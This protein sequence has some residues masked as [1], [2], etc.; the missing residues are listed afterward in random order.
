MTKDFEDYLVLEMPIHQ[1]VSISFYVYQTGD[2]TQGSKFV[3]SV[4]GTFYKHKGTGHEHP[5]GS[6]GMLPK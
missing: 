4:D 3:V 6:Y 2:H 1:A 5:V